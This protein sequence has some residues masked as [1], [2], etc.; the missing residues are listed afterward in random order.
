ME[1][2]AQKGDEDCGV[3]CVAMLIQRYAGCPAASSYDAAR[4]VMFGARDI[5]LTKGK[6]LA[7]AL[8][9]FGV[10][11]KSKKQPFKPPSKNK[12]GLDFDAIVGTEP[13]KDNS[14]HWMIWDSV[15]K[16]LLDPDR[17]DRNYRS[18][19]HYLKVSAAP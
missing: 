16:V 12:M 10:H 18:V 8:E 13:R 9:A 1:R 3:A 14:W 15:N 17:P 5:G 6:D 11:L 7:K 4:A 2:V 19:T